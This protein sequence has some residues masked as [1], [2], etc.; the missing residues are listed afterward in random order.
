MIVSFGTG[1]TVPVRVGVVPAEPAT[2]VTGIVNVVLAD[3]TNPAVFGVVQVTVWPDV[4]QVHP[5]FENDVGAVRLFG[6]TV[7][8]VNEPVAGAVPILATVTGINDV[9]PSCNAGDGCPILAT[10]SGRSI[11]TIGEIG[12]TEPVLFAMIASVGTGVTVPEIVGVVLAVPEAGVTGILNDTEVV[13][14]KPVV[15][16]LIQVTVC[17]AVEHT[18][19]PSVNDAGA[20]KPFGK[21]VIN[22][23]GPVA[24]ALPIF[25]IVTGINEVIPSCNAGAG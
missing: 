6:N 12:V 20:D 15:F 24:D 22:V 19:A 9:T 7:V 10:K 18:Q 5:L 8:N 13:G 17:P 4:V 23:N 16:P 11:D 21:V 1:A 3:G 2:E 14:T 25:A